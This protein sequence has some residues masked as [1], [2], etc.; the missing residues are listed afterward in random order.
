MVWLHM[1]YDAVGYHLCKNCC[2]HVLC[3]SLVAYSNIIV[4]PL[5][6]LNKWFAA[7]F[8]LD[9]GIV[10][11]LQL[12]YFYQRGK[13]NH[14]KIHLLAYFLL[15][16]YVR[17]ERLLSVQGWCSQETFSPMELFTHAVIILFSFSFVP[18]LYLY[19]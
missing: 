4:C 13:I 15:V 6:K 11:V 3:S 10:C 17:C 16:C 8:C 5:S 1:R 18:L 19:C 7:S 12:M 9:S 2:M 14:K